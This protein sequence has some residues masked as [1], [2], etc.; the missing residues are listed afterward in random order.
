MST[1]LSGSSPLPKVS[2]YHC[3]HDWS[4]LDGSPQAHLSPRAVIVFTPSLQFPVAYPATKASSDHLPEL[5]RADFG[6]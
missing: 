2:P 5:T 1:L 6:V 3:R 4:M